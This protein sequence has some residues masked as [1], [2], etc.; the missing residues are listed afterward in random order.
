MD[1]FGT[2]EPHGRRLIH[3]VNGIYAKSTD[4]TINHYA[5]K[6]SSSRP[7]IA[8]TSAAGSNSLIRLVP[9]A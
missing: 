8:I 5:W 7:C 3:L 6:L 4:S 9:V 1:C 2:P